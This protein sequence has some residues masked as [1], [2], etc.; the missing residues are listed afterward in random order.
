MLDKVK[1]LVTV[2]NIFPQLYLTPEEVELGP[3][4]IFLDLSEKGFLLIIDF[5]ASHCRRIRL[6]VPLHDL[7]FGPFSQPLTDSQQPVHLCH[8]LMLQISGNER[9]GNNLKIALILT[10]MK[11]L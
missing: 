4:C 8:L 7:F 11:P 9:F 6:Q 10:V 3:V 5:K 2:D 1:I